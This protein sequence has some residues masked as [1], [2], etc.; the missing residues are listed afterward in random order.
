MKTKIITI[1]G[2]VYSSLGKGII[3]SSIGRILT[4]LGY[5]VAMQKMDPYL[6]YNSGNL[7]P[8]QHG[9]VFVTEDGGEG[10]LDL[11]NYERFTGV[12][13]TKDSDITS[14]VIYGEVINDERKGKY[15][16][17]TIQVIPHITNAIK[18]KINSVIEKINP[19]FLIIEIGGTVGDLESLPFVEA[20]SQF[21][22]EYGRSDFL[23]I[24]A[25]PLIKLSYGDEIK[26]KPA[27]HA[28]KSL[29]SLGIIPNMIIL[30]YSDKV[31]DEIFNKLS[32]TCHV[33]KE[34]IFLSMDLPSIYLLPGELYKQKIQDAI[35]K[36]FDIKYNHKND[37]FKQWADY[38]KKIGKLTKKVKIAFVGKYISLKD[39]YRSMIESLRFAGYENNHVL[40]IKWV[41]AEKL[42][43]K[44]V[45]RSLGD[46]H[47]ILIAGGFGVRGVDGKITAIK[48]AR[49]NNIPIFGV[50]LGMQLMLIEYARNVMGL[51]N[52]NSTEF[53]PKALAIFDSPSKTMQL[54]SRNCCFEKGTLANK[55]Y[56]SEKISERF[57]H[58]Y[59]FNNTLAEEFKK[60]GM[61]LSGYCGE[62]KN[63][64]SNIELKNHPFFFGCQYHPE[65]AGKPQNA[66]LAFVEFIKA[67]IS[68]KNK[69][70]ILKKENV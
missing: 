30:R 9:E 69:N 16:G 31:K 18:D 33:N 53:D 51:K 22:S 24:I 41:D 4:Q 55:I 13:C 20:I 36:H 27:Q 34:N 32:L 15:L 26:T 49:E 70:K 10:D 50:C 37:N 21:A 57:R 59:E 1:F 12:N 61:G 54:G 56:K 68:K 43:E 23:S 63:V 3:A 35:F 28:F 11:G 65:Y 6:N 58:R 52:A 67:S 39:S 45:K 42:T 25:A 2:G 44:N 66:D 8:L 7:S 19:D 29:C 40:D 17:S 38:I 62:E 5:K 14:G 48:Y 46:C 64:L 47:G 60:A